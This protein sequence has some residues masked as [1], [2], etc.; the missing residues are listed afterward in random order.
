LSGGETKK[1]LYIDL[2]NTMVDFRA[3]IDAVDESVLAQYQGRFDEL[4]GV[5]ALMKPV[6]GAI[7]AFNELSQL[8]DS[9]ILST[10]PWGNPSAWQHKLEWVQLHLGID[11]DS[12]AYKRLILTHHKDRNRGDF[13]VDDRPNNGADRFEG[14]WIQFGSDRFPDWPAVLDYLRP[15]A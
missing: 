5:F 12:P 6:R 3:R 13:L 15:K 14:E 2:D 1:V 8:F 7:D 9:Y 11:E 10:A 4:P